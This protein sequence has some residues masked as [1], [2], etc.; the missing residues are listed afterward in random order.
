MTWSDEIFIDIVPPE[1]LFTGL[2]NEQVSFFTMNG[3]CY[4]LDGENYLVYDGMSVKEIVPYIPTLS[5]SKEPSGGGTHYE[6]FNLLGAGF[7]DS[8]SAD[9]GATEFVL[10]LKGLD[11]IEVTA[12]VNGEEKE[13]GTDFTVDRDEGKVSFSQAPVKG[14]NNVII[15]AYKTQLGLSDRIKKCRF[16][17]IFGGNND[18]RVFLSGNKDMPEYVWASELYDPTYFPENRFYKFPD[19]VMGFAKQYDYLVV[20]R[21]HGKH[22]IGFELVQ[23]ESSFPSRPINDQVGTF[24]RNSIQI[25]ENNPVSLSRRGVYMLTASNVRDERNVAHISEAIDAKLLREP[26][27]DKAVTVEFDKKY[28]LALNGNVY[29][30]DYV[31]R[32]WYVYDNIHASCF[33]EIDG[34]LYFGSSVDGLIYRFKKETEG[35]AYNDDGKAINAHWRSKHLTFGASEYNKLVERV[36]F[37]LKPSTRT[38]V[39][40]YYVSNKKESDLVKT[41]RMDLLDFRDMDFNNFTFLTSIFPQESMAKIKAKKITHF[42]LMLKNDKVDESLGILSLGIKYKHQNYVK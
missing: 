31:I 10:S 19:K 37:S 29:I 33:L 16:H 32:E 26:D 39:D 8:F 36:F 38:S 28:W 5:V 18:T 24:A 17:V 1:E 9:G 6:D 20:E 30:Y 25:I 14:T 35:L 40:L 27:L 15:T 4:I 23:G 11:D 22:H 12:K 3:S 2:S 42:Q 41:S 13:E 21:A 34:D 7:K